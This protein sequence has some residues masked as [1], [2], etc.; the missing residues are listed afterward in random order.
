MPNRLRFT[1]ISLRALR[2][3]DT[4]VTYWDETMP[5]FGLR[6]G[7]R[8]KTFLVVHG[9]GRRIKIG[10]FPDV[11]LADARKEAKRLLANPAPQL[12]SRTPDVLVLSAVEVFLETRAAKN[13]AS[14][15]AE[16]ERVLR[17]H[18]LP[19]LGGHPVNEITSEHIT[20]IIDGLAETPGT[21]NHVFTAMRTFFNWS[22]ARRYITHSPMAGMSLPAKPGERDRVLTDAE[23]AAVYRAA[24]DMSHPFG[25]IVLLCIHT[26]LR[27]GEV[28]ALKWSY[29]T[30][31]TITIPAELAK[32]GEVH[33]I[34]N[35][36]GNNLL[37][38]PKTSDYLFPSHAGTPFSAWS[39]NK[40]R[41]DARCGVADWV[42]HDLRRTFSTKMAEW[43]IAP[44]HVTER[45]LNHTVGS[46]TPIA[47]VYNRWNYLAEM[48]D[49]LERYEKRLAQLLRDHA[50]V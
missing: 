23:L 47:R 39:K 17:R 37:L 48:R 28:G 50:Q 12:A 18:L 49:A 24:A 29:I 19:D 45:L 10:R 31:E 14:T 3:S 11:S 36:I 5:A 40:R 43:Q 42:L 6:I 7:L 35:L 46:L 44:P 22:V 20:S 8:S 1:D 16:T 41:L 34:P 2:H 15:K 30:Q 33:M 13:R 32:N 26:G 4:L 25:Y 9:G 21:A 38:I 27:R